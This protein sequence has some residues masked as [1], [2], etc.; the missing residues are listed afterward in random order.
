MDTGRVPV[1]SKRTS[2]TTTKRGKALPRRAQDLS[3]E[4][5]LLTLQKKKECNA[6]ALKIV[7]GMLEASVQGEWFLDMLQHINQ[8]HLQDITEERAIGKLCGYPLCTNGLKNVP[9]QQ[10]RISTKLNK[11]YDITERKNFCSNKCFTAYKFIKDQMYTSPLWLRDIEPSVKFQ[12]MSSTAVNVGAG[13][14]VNVQVERVSKEEVRQLSQEDH[15]SSKLRS[16]QTPFMSEKL[17]VDALDSLQLI[18]SSQGSSPTIHEESFESKIDTLKH[19]GNTL[20]GISEETFRNEDKGILTEE[21][22][23]NSKMDV[24]AEPPRNQETKLTEEY[25]TQGSDFMECVGMRF[26]GLSL[27]NEQFHQV[28]I[29]ENTNNVNDKIS[30]VK[31]EN[32]MDIKHE[33][34]TSTPKSKVDEKSKILHNGVQP[35]VFSGKIVQREIMK[36]DVPLGLLVAKSEFSTPLTTEIC[37]TTQLEPKDYVDETSENASKIKRAVQKTKSCSNHTTKYS[38]GKAGLNQKRLKVDESQK[39]ARSGSPCSNSFPIVSHVEKCV[40]EWF[41]METMC[42][43]FGESALKEMLEQKGESIQAHYKA[44]SSLTW[45]QEKHERFLTICKRLKLFDIEDSKFDNQVVKSEGDAARK[46]LPDYT[47]LKR[48]AESMELKVKAFYRGTLE[49]EEKK[50][51]FAEDVKDNSKDGELDGEPQIPLVHLHSQRALRKKIVLDGLNRVLPDFLRTFGIRPSE[52][53]SSVRGLIGT[54]ALSSTNITFKPQEWS[55]LGLIVIK[56]LSVREFELKQS[57][58]QEQCNTYLTLM[59]MS[60]KQEPGYLDRLLL[61]LADIDRLLARLE[62]KDE[63]CS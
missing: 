2:K 63:E 20:M 61:W 31:M 10:F 22:K 50:V 19:T 57:L 17:L 53:T 5:L 29:N 23:T 15:P 4:E 36:E 51:S 44:L 3:K 60:Y 11:V 56:L 32:A 35:Q 28:F 43:L 58:Q 14:E 39:N 62:T 9:S 54:F 16:H 13:D 33:S 12:L 18:T 46:P 26:D 45:D 8:S 49:V 24:T 6:R 59:L 47:A 25:K 40:K 55:L 41:T 7:E 38:E 1:S 52:M 34:P 27:N 30:L 37:P 21:N 48:E 42:F